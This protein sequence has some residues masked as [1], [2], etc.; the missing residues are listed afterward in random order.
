[1]RVPPRGPPGRRARGVRRD[2]ASYS[3]LISGHA[4]LG[5][6]ARAVAALLR[7]MRLDGLRPTEYTFVGL[8]TACARW[9]NPRLGAAFAFPGTSSLEERERGELSLSVTEEQW[10]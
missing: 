10:P 8:L 5:S 7:R 1:V 2:A 6:P 9:G 3:A 4:R